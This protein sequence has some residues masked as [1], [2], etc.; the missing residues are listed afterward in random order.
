MDDPLALI[1][2]EPSAISAA[3]ESKSKS[4][5]KGPSEL[6][7]KKEE[8]LNMKEQ[9]LHSGV[10]K[11]KTST[12]DAQPSPPPPKVDVSPLLDQISAYK[13]R[14]PHLKSRNAKLSAKSSAE[15]VED[16]L[17]YIEMQLGSQKDGSFGCQ[18]FVTSLS[19]L[20]S[21]SQSFN[22]LGLNLTGLGRVA[23]DN[24]Q[25]FA[26][27]IDE[28]MIKYGAGLYMPPEVRLVC[29]TPGLVL[30]VHQANNGNPGVLEAMRK[31]NQ[32]V[33]PP[34]NSSDL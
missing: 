6:E 16:E 23:T 3:I 19:M 9:R 34:A 32:S 5:L 33:T 21:A 4:K 18:I 10:A 15:E 12:K 11:L 20:E 1:D 31:V 29:M 26:P 22:P 25:Q 8:R 28:L 2:L 13:E 17:H 30:T 24:V 27:V 14:F 7:V